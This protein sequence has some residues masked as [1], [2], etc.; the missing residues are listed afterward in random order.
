MALTGYPLHRENRQNGQKF[1]VKENT[2]TLEILPKR[3]ENTGH[4]VCSSFKF[5]DSK[6]KRYFKICCDYL[7]IF[8]K[9]AKSV[10]YIY[11][12]VTNHVNWHRGNLPLDRENTGNLKMQFD[13]V[14]CITLKAFKQF[15]KLIIFSRRGFKRGL[16]YK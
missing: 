7:Q 11:V 16:S 9:L 5:P 10:L 14:H 15:T 1:P 12:I 6:G 3:R 2:G 4:L 13:S 8:F